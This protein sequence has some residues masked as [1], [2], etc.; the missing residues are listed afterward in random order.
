M[1]GQ[2]VALHP[3][4]VSKA[5]DSFPYADFPVLIRIGECIG[6]NARTKGLLDYT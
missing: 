3:A 6:N 2:N 4:H 1:D 5:L